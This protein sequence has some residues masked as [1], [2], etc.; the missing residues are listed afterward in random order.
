MVAEGREGGSEM[1]NI[2]IPLLALAL[3]IPAMIGLGRAPAP[4]VALAPDATLPETLDVGDAHFVGF[5]VEP[6]EAELN[7]LTGAVLSKR[8]YTLPLYFGDRVIFQVSTIV[9]GPDK[10]SLHRPEIC[11]P[12][13]GFT[14]GAYRTLT[15]GDVVWHV[16]DLLGPE[17]KPVALFAYTFV[18]QD[19]YRTASHESRIWRDIWD[20]SIHNRVDRW[21]MTSVQ[22][23]HT[24]TR[25]L[26]PILAALK[27]LGE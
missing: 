15:V 24:D 9:S 7:L 11:L 8:A 19:G 21:V 5:A 25:V 20:R 26:E 6:S 12:S 16:I 4:E 17:D 10:N 2:L 1:K 3:F 27:G 13:Q 22:L 23:F 14:M 18:N